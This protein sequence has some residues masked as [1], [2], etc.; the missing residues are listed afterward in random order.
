MLEKTEGEIKNGQSKE[1]SNIGHTRYQT[2]DKKKQQQKETQ[3]NRC[4]TP[5]YVNKYK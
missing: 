1:T 5:L 4:W 2:E 3:R